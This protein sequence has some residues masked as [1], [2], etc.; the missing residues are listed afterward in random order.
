MDK[1][2][3]IR[4]IKNGCSGRGAEVIT[5]AGRFYGIQKEFW[6]VRYENFIRRINSDGIPITAFLAPKGNW[7]A[8]VAMKLRNDQPMV[9]MIGSSNLT[10]PAYKEPFGNFSHECDVVIWRDD[11]VLNSYFNEQLSRDRNL[12]DPF[13]PIEVNFNREIRQLDERRRLEALYRE[14]MNPEI[15]VRFEAWRERRGY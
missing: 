5:V 8:K 15:L 3:L 14:I 7:H 13:A 2:E 9:A 10:A 1:C 6:K 12:S 11:P 4:A